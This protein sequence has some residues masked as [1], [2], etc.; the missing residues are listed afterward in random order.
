MDKEPIRKLTD[1]L[2]EECERQNIS[3]VCMVA[4]VSLYEQNED[5]MLGAKTHLSIRGN[6]NSVG[7]MTSALMLETL[8]NITKE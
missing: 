6:S 4:D 7:M 8:Q 1:M 3:L 2:Y 5:A